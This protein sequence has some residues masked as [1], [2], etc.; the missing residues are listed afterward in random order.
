L[1]RLYAALCQLAQN[2]FHNLRFLL[3]TRSSSLCRSELA[4]EEPE[5]DAYIQTASVTV[6]EHREQARSYKIKGIKNAPAARTG[7]TGL[8]HGTQAQ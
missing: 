1:Q 6:D 7:G 2:V 5:N 8:I 3:W 4:R